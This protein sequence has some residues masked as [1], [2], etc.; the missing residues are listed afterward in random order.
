MSKAQLI[1]NVAIL[2]HLHHGK[3]LLSDMLI[4]STHQTQR[5]I[6]NSFTHTKYTDSRLD[7]IE[8]KISLKAAPFQI[9][10][11]DSVGKSYAYNFMD[12]PGHPDFLDE[13]CASLRLADNVVLVVDVL[14]GCTTYTEKLIQKVIKANKELLVF[15]NKIDRLV[16]ELKMPPDDAYHMIKRCLDNLNICIQKFKKQYPNKNFNNKRGS[17]LSPLHGNVVFGS[18]KYSLCFTLESFA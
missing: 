14:E 11:Q 5:T 12:T 10:L 9:L 6:D 18:T 1:R 13:V 3:T 4:E 7:E 17:Y 15:I 8:R 16:L 2:G